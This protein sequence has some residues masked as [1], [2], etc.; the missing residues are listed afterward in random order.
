MLCIMLGSMLDLIQ[1]T[2]NYLTDFDPVSM[3]CIMLGSMLDLIQNTHNYV[4]Y[5]YANSNSSSVQVCGLQC[6]LYVCVYI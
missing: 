6:F 4:H 5:F 2:H 1:N 3:L